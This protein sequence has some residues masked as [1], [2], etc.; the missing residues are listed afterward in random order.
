MLL[1]FVTHYCALRI[2]TARCRALRWCYGELR[3]VLLLR[4]ATALP[5]CDTNSYDTRRCTTV[6]YVVA[7]RQCVTLVRY[8]TLHYGA[9]R[10]VTLRCKT[11]Q[12]VMVLPSVAARC[13]TLRCVTDRYGTLRRVTAGYFTAC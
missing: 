8:G 13:K 7:L 12:H 6:S 11:L 4:N 2:V 1:H 9:I 5:L 10:H 3:C